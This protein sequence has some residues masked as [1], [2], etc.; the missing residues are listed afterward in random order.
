[1]TDENEI[2]LP[3]IAEE[4]VVRSHKVEDVFSYPVTC[5]MAFV[6]IGQGGGRIA[7]TFWK[8]GYRRV[9]VL[10]SAQEDLSGLDPEIPKL[11]FGTGGAGQNMTLGRGFVEERQEDIIDTLERAMGEDID[12][13]NVCVSFGGGTGG[14]G[15]ATLIKCCRQYM[16][17]INRNPARVGVFG[18]LPVPY[19]GQRT[20]RNAYAAFNQVLT[21]N[22]TPLVVIDNKR[23]SELYRC[24]STKF[25]GV[26]NDQVCKLFHLFNRYTKIDNALVTFDEADYVTL[27]DSGIITF[28][29]AQVKNYD[30]KADLSES[31]RKSWKQS[32]LAEVDTHS[33]K[34]AGC[35]FMGGEKIMG[36][37]PMDWFGHAFSMLNRLIA[38]GDD[39]DP[40][41]YRGVYIGSSNDLR[42]YTM[43]AGLKPP[44]ERLREL[45]KEGRVDKAATGYADQLGV[46]DA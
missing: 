18:S 9:A 45:A 1:M 5:K 13:L 7:E 11:D 24:G 20:C 27:L 16:A 8:L 26:C 43:L 34:S 28:G 42:C 35:V 36:E 41:L 46:G 6:G 37:V 12:F 38:N 2:D 3:E 40:P 14:G 21:L 44:V 22:P 4:P 33:G 29:A 39:S 15:A 10:N 32:V 30:T 31:I 25:F 19:E 17:S 23:I